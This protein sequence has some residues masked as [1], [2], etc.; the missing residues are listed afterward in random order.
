LLKSVI[1]RQIER[2]GLLEGQA[3]LLSYNWLLELLPA[4]TASSDE[5]AR[6]LTS[7]GLELEEQREIGVGLE[8][9][10]IVEVQKIEPHP[11]RDKLRLVTVTD[12]NTSQTVVCGASNVPAPGGLVVLAPL[13]AY[14]PAVDLKL[15]P[16]KLGG[17]M[18]EGMLCSEEE[19]GLAPS[20]EGILTFEPGRFPA[21]TS[22]Y[23]AF[24]GAKD[25]IFGIG[26]TPNRP[27]AL[28]HRGVARDLAAAFGVVF[29]PPRANLP[30]P[31][32]KTLASLVTVRNE[33][34]SAC[35]RYGAGLVSKLRVAAS[36]EWLRWRLQGLGVRPISNIVDVTNLVLLEFGNPMHAF[37]LAS[38]KGRTIVIRQARS[39]EQIK[40]LDG[41]MRTLLPND[42]VIAD[43]ETATAVAGVMGGATSEIRES[44]E[45][46]LLEAAYFTPSG[47][48][49]TARRLGMHTDSSYRFERGVNWDALH[50]VLARSISLLLELAG[51]TYVGHEF[52]DGA[53]LALPEIMLRKDRLNQL[54]GVDVPFDQACALLRTLGFETLSQDASKARLQGAPWRP[55][56]TMEADLIEEVARIRGLDSIP[57]RLP[58]IMPQP[59]STSGKLERTVRH[60]AASLGLSEAVCYSFVAPAD[61]QALGAPQPTVRLTHPL[62]EE[63]SVL[64]TTLLP[65]LV[66]AYRRAARRG[67]TNVRLFTVA[68]RFMTIRRQVTTGAGQLA[69]PVAQT[70]IGALPQE[71]LSFAAL[72]A[73]DRASYLSKAEAVDVF[74]VKGI[75]I[76][77]VHHLT[78]HEAELQLAPA[79]EE[80]QHLHPRGS[81]HVF[82]N[83]TIVGRLGPLHPAVAE[84]LDIESSVFVLELELDTI[85]SI[86]PVRKRYRPIPKLPAVSRDVALEAPETLAASE[87]LNAL[88]QGGGDLCESVE[89]FDLFTGSN[90]EEGRRSLA[91]RIVYR[92]PKAT[93]DPDNATTLTDKQV[94]K[95]HEKVLA[96]VQKLGITLRT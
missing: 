77:L 52:H 74:D 24:P 40:T 41:E 51:G 6:K 66:E 83:G 96:S 72:M 78:G 85:E 50:D 20:A 49:R 31:S 42:L 19:L 30:A 58:A 34:T 92:D 28:G 9:L 82:C 33:A 59:P 4:L 46:V 32:E 62:T 3:M 2:K 94:D 45:T 5:V 17:V 87:I 56:V 86:E 89:L 1:F 22:F 70:D 27:D 13:G 37:D 29:T 53:P 7:I 84:R 63:R 25:T 61:L 57:P 35:P 23:T 43:A 26:V 54:L 15:E 69:R 12:G 64:T 76:D 73:G 47:I 93:T 38:V 79:S 8:A 71:R 14:L 10:R 18:S 81:A 11:N 16:R 48:R 55:D 68:S 80:T 67:Q 95:Q 91:F 75:A 36:P 88:K 65:G 60:L 21:G 44:T 90:L 39:G